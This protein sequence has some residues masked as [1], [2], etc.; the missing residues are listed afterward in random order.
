METVDG[1]FERTD[2]IEV[3][4][5]RA[6]NSLFAGCVWIAYN[7]IIKEKQIIDDDVKGGCSKKLVLVHRPSRWKLIEVLRNEQ[8]E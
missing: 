1:R 6:E 2:E 8:T 7:S 3:P 4:R 5:S